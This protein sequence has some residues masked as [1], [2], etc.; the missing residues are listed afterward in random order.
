MGGPDNLDLNLEAMQEAIEEAKRQE[1][2]E[3]LRKALEE[4]S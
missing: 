2:A 4:N 3:K 1:E